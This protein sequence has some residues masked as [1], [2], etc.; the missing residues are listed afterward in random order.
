MGKKKRTWVHVDKI[1]GESSEFDNL[2]IV[3]ELTDYNDEDLADIIAESNSNNDD[4]PKK[5]KKKYDKEITETSEIKNASECEKDNQSKSKTPVLEKK[6]ES[7]AKK[8]KAR[9]NNKKKKSDANTN[10]QEEVKSGN[11]NPEQDS[12]ESETDIV[13]PTLTPDL[14]DIKDKWGNMGIHDEI[15]HGLLDKRFMSPTEIQKKC[16]P[17]G[18]GFKDVVGAAE[19]GIIYTLFESL[20]GRVLAKVSDTF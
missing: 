13:V 20:A 8:K 18:I 1:K 12:T 14:T 17:R 6:T 10:N 15:L 3:E 5:K 19:T 9:K 4:P 2:G 7:K 11:K 16:I